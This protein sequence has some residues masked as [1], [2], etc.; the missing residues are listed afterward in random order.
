MQRE[1]AP[2]KPLTP[3]ERARAITE[4]QSRLPPRFFGLSAEGARF[5]R[6]D[7]THDRT[8]KTDA[9]ERYALTAK[10]VA[11]FPYV[12]WSNPASSYYQCVERALP[13]FWTPVNV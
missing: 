9:R 13:V 2:P 6:H 10:E 4:I 3:G 12:E 7:E 8:N 1:E 5:I 11:Q